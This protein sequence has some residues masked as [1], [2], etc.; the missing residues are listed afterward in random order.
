MITK[1]RVALL[2]ASCLT[3]LVACSSAT[4]SGA[5][6]GS[7]AVS[8]GSNTSSGPVSCH[9]HPTAEEA[10]NPYATCLFGRCCGSVA[11]CSED[12]TC[13]RVANCVAEATSQSEGNECVAALEAYERLAS[14]LWFLDYFSCINAQCAS[15]DAVEGAPK[16][17]PCAAYKSCSQCLNGAGYQAAGATGNCGWSGEACHAGS[18]RGPDDPSVQDGWIFFDDAM[19]PGAGGGSSG[20]GGCTH[21]V[22]CGHCRR[23]ER[24]T[25]NCLTRVA[26]K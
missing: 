19:C 16:P 4:T 18:T 11:S 9:G 17:D 1:N 21:D 23:C 25:G 12:E 7:G 3:I 24:S 5:E 2:T 20:G 6:D 22:D 15:N 14:K 26:C 8:P 10:E 13:A